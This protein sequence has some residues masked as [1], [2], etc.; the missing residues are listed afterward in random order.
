MACIEVI[1]T[2]KQPQPLTGLVSAESLRESIGKSAAHLD[3][4]NVYCKPHLRMGVQSPPH[5]PIFALI[6][7]E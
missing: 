5:Q 6:R 7:E 3:F 1:S 2:P 4:A